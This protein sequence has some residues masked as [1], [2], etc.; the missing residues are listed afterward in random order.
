MRYSL[1]FLSLLIT[2]CTA[3][4][5]PT[6]Q[7]AGAPEITTLSCNGRS[8]SLCNFLNTPVK[9]DDKVI[10]LPGRDFPF[11]LTSEPLTFVDAKK[12]QWV[13]PRGTMT[14]GASIPTMF[15]GIM[16]HPRSK[17][18]LNAAVVHDAYCA[19]GNEDGGYYHT[20]TWQNVHRM[21]YD[22][23]R[24]SGVP[25]VKAKTMYAALYLGGPRWSGSKRPRRQA[26]LT[27]NSNTMQYGS[28]LTPSLLD[29]LDKPMIESIL[30][31]Q[32]SSAI[33][34]ALRSSQSNRALPT[35]VSTA[36]LKSSLRKVK[37]FI[38]ATNPSIDKVESYLTREEAGLT[39]RNTARKKAV[40]QRSYENNGGGDGGNDGGSSH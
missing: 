2:G 28:V 16:G 36:K 23:I 20:A 9:F 31:P 17:Q 6:S 25:A 40:P 10:E 24:V 39:G 32:T 11:S 15:V 27:T 37:A 7:L 29:S 21:F 26:A 14:D 30:T 5:T 8:S 22:A 12:K 38:E 18:F 33:K 34:I 35:R 1:A 4:P 19:T 13:A 3:T